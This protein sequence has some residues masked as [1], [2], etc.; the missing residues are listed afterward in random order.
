[1]RWSSLSRAGL[2]ALTLAFS[3]APRAFAASQGAVSVST[4]PSGATLSLDGSALGTT[5]FVELLVA[6]G[7]HRLELALDGFKPVEHEFDLV[8]GQKLTLDITLVAAEPPP[9]AVLASSSAPVVAT[10]APTRSWTA[11]PWLDV[12]WPSWIAGGIAA[13]LFGVGLG[14]GIAASNIDHLAGVDVAPSGV[15][16]GL[17][18]ATALAGQQDALI[19][20][21]LL[22]SAGVVAIA[23]LGF[24]AL[25]PDPHANDPQPAV[26]GK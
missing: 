15:D 10:T 4:V 16:M 22:I 7:H 24:A 3:A 25:A 26:N 2:L 21:I 6:A 9:P 18:R 5:P 13:G 17:T 14:F 1:V 11:H 12:P 20:N 19:A 8:D 23:G